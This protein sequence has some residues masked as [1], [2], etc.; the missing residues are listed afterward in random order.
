KALA[1]GNRKYVYLARQI[2]LKRDYVVRVADEDGWEVVSKITIIDGS[3]TMS[4]LLESKWE[5]ARLAMQ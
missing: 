1:S 2:T 4:E 5:S 3:N